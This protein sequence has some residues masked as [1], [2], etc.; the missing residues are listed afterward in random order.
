MSSK[1]MYC[2]E[3]TRKTERAA[4]LDAQQSMIIGAPSLRPILSG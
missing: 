4:K 1:Q 2:Y 3:S